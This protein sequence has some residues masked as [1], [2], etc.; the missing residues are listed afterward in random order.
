MHN[1]QVS[2]YCTMKIYCIQVVSGKFCECTNFLCDR[3]NGLL[4]SGPDHGECVCNEC[5]C[6]PGWTGEACNCEDSEDNCL[7]PGK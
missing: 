6:K 5:K 4:C 2:F 1:P 3:H 7:N